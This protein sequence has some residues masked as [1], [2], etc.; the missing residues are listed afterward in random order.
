MGCG[1]RGGRGCDSGGGGGGSGGAA[2]CVAG[3]HSGHTDSR[4]ARMGVQLPRAGV[5]VA[6]VGRVAAAHNHVDARD[7][8]VSPQ[9]HTF[10]S[11][12]RSLAAAIALI[13]E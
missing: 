5:G 10:E 9:T 2:L 3:C 6:A 8:V 12:S 11:H 4:R 7:C 1:G 13:A